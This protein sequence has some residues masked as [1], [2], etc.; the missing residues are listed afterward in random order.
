M[1]G[2]VCV[3]R[4][5]WEP[6][7]ARTAKRPVDVLRVRFDVLCTSAPRESLPGRIG[8][9]KRIALQNAPVEQPLAVPPLALSERNDIVHILCVE[10]YETLRVEGDF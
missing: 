7:L 6:L 9:L 2:V 3:S 10:N 5:N 4:S 1:S 8:V